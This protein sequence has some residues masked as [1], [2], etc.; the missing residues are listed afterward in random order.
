MS[1][2]L[3]SIGLLKICVECILNRIL[4][5]F[6]KNQNPKA[7]LNLFSLSLD[8]SISNTGLPSYNL[9]GM[10]F[11]TFDQDNDMYPKNCATS[12]GGGWWFNSCHYA[13]LNGP[14]NSVK[15]VSPWNPPFADGALINR[16]VMMI[17]PLWISHFER[18]ACVLLCTKH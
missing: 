6:N 2:E 12:F 3:I 7:H 4:M 17:K 8:D 13:F 14:M 11:T 9:D 16:T 18:K 5:F 10:F 1:Q 15:W